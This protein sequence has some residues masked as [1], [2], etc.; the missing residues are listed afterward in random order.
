MAVFFNGQVL[1]TP[2][3]SSVVLDQGMLDQNP[4]TGNTLAI[5]GI[6]AGGVPNVPT[7][8]HSIPDARAALVSGDLLRAVELAFSPSAETGAPQSICAVRI[9]TPLQSSLTL[10]NSASTGVINLVSTDYGVGTNNIKVK[11]ETSTD[12]N[13]KKV[14]VNKGTT[15]YVGDNLWRNALCVYYSGSSTYGLVTLNDA[16]ISL[17]VASTATTVTADTFSFDAYPTVQDVANRINTNVGSGWVASVVAGSAERSSAV[18]ENVTNKNVKGSSVTSTWTTLTQHTAAIVEWINSTQEGLLTATRVTGATLPPANIAF[19]Y[20]SGGSDG[21]VPTVVD[22]A[23]GLNTLQTEDV[24]WIVPLSSDQLVW[25][26][27]SAHLGYMSSIG[28]RER[29]GFVGGAVGTTKA[30]ALTNAASINDDRVG[31]CFP[32]IFQ[33]NDA[34]IFAKRT[35]TLYPAYMTAV[36]IAAGFAGMSPGETM[37]NKSIKALGL[38]LALVAPADTD[39]LIQGGVLSLYKDAKG[40]F[41]C[42]RALST[43]LNDTRYNRVEISTGAVVDYVSRTVRDVV[44]AF[45]GKKG[46]PITLKTVNAT[47]EST[48]YRFAQPEP[49]G[50]GMLVGDADFPAYRNITSSLDGDT[51]RLS[52]ECSPA[53]P[54]NYVLVSIHITPFSTTIEAA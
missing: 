2:G 14:T 3:V 41:R 44:Q 16:A 49:V 8:F 20:L 40:T 10:N 9:G 34:S 17:S 30:T 4:A 32:G 54:I 18:F 45:V 26:A 12:G 46:T 47:V 36:L 52:F 42:A 50:L 35:P 11:V 53:I 1:T 23:N 13:G 27:L 39:A 43:W 33:Y 29:R 24:Q 25:A 38:E 19:T 31:Y 15:Q 6:S 21:S 5:L 7:Y 51:L 48:L 28:K 37:T 22:W